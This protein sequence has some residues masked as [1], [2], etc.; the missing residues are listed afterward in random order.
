MNKSERFQLAD[1]NNKDILRKLAVP[2]KDYQRKRLRPGDKV[3]ENTFKSGKCKIIPD[4]DKLRVDLED[5]KVGYVKKGSVSH[6]KK[7]LSDPNYSKCEVE[8]SGGKYRAFDLDGS[9]NMKEH[10]GSSGLWAN[11]TIFLKRKL[12]G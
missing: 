7:L 3:Y 10:K 12:F 11:L 1:I 8:I 5:V 2:N 4:D 6:V 9:G